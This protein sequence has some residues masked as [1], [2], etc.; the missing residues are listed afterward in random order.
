MYVKCTL[1]YFLFYFILFL[2]ILFFFTGNAAFLLVSNHF[3]IYPHD[4]IK[5]WHF[6]ASIQ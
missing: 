2:F 3:E 1:F 6:C 5:V 4:Q